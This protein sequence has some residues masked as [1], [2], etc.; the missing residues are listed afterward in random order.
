MV[1][2]ESITPKKRMQENMPN[3]KQCHG[4]KGHWR[5]QYL[6]FTF[7]QLQVHNWNTLLLPH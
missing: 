6:K 2:Y 1:S 4:L 7:S 3:P 5:K